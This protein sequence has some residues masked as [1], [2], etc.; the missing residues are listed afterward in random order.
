MLI[1]RLLEVDASSKVVVNEVKALGRNR[2]K[3]ASIHS[4]NRR[5]AKRRNVI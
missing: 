2:E 3:Y 4:S 1:I 5:N